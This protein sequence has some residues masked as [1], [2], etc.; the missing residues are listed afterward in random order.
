MDIN[1][2]GPIHKFHQ[3]IFYEN[4]STNLRDDWDFSKKDRETLIDLTFSNAQS[5]RVSN[6][7]SLKP[8]Y[9]ES[10]EIYGKHLI[11]N[12]YSV[13]DFKNEILLIIENKY[14]YTRNLSELKSTGEF[15]EFIAMIYYE[16]CLH[17]MV[18]DEL[19]A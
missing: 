16:T 2:T 14:G 11:N 18:V 17:A 8:N 6:L 1:I 7:Y 19:T 3:I 15:I 4:G 13:N 9:I 10:P 12:S 5:I